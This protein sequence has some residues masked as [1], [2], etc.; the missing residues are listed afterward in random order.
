M[1]WF[2]IACI[3]WVIA[4][5]L[6]AAAF[7]ASETA[8]KAGV[9]V[10]AVIAVLVG[11]GVFAL[12]GLKSVP[13]KNIGVP[14]SFGRVGGTAYQPGIHETWTP[15]LHLVD[16]NETVQTTT[17]EDTGNDSGSSCNGGLPVR[18]GGQQTACADLTVQWQIQPAAAGSLFSDYAVTGS[19]M[20]E[21]TNAVV[22]RELK[23]VTNQVLGDYNPIT[24][25]QQVTNTN[26]ATSQFTTFS[27][28]IKSAMQK[29]LNGRIKVIA[30]LMPQLH[31]SNSIEAKLSAIQ[32]AYANYA[33]AQENVK[34][35]EEN[36]AALQKL[37]T[38]SGSQLAAEC[39]TDLKDGM[40]APTG[41]QCLPGAGSG[42]ALSGK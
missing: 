29:D 27:S 13:V 40:N 8:Q 34:V 3:I 14:T 25:V 21:V 42:L 19:F 4:L 20:P 35:N 22:V 23:Q 11:F 16:I 2:I 30:V 31:Y 36:S 18:I 5:V 6:A 9:G 7:F 12:A 33:V 28:T 32:Q 1:G 37:G 26:S 39:L 24:D 17:W 38:P 41:F 15:W 10:L